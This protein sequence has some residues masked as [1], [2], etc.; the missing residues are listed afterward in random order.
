M[1]FNQLQLLNPQ[2]F[3]QVPPQF[4]PV[5]QVFFPPAGIFAFETAFFH[6]LGMIAKCLSW[7]RLL[8]RL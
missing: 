2:L 4:L 8:Q 1:E 6:I 7:F 5:C 3:Q